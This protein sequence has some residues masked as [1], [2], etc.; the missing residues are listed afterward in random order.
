MITAAMVFGVLGTGTKN[1][2]IFFGI[3]IIAIVIQRVVS[4][5]LTKSF[6]KSSKLL[7]VDE[8]NYHFLR[9]FISA[10]IIIGGV[11]VAIYSIPQLKALSVSLFAGAGILAVIVGFASQQA[12][13]NI[14]SGIFIVIFK[15]FRV[16]D[17][18]TIGNDLRGIVEDINL[19]HTVIR[20]FENK[21]IIVPNS[22][23]SNDKIENASITDEKICRYI[24][25]S[26]SYDSSIDKAM[27]IMEREA[28]K[29][30]LHIDNRDSD[31]KK[32]NDPIVRVRVL[33]LG[34]SSVNLRAW[35][36]A[37]N[38]NNAFIMSCDLNKS[39]KEA[40]D[41]EGIEIPYPYR[42]IVYKKDLPKNKIDLPK[43]NGGLSK[44]NQGLSRN[45][46]YLSKS[47]KK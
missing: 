36:W 18:I 15:P 8:T 20:N 7:K 46:V 40:F 28:L 43:N 37:K 3:V 34:D 13:A 16:G 44:N 27:K 1:T 14:V 31:E 38:S 24:D 10:S 30:P 45:N 4:K 6:K 23:I 35:V 32:N 29:H 21:R 26:I 33:S 41:K 25:F 5:L 47:K 19:R 42:T 12:F 22:M 11:G 17:R 9:H 39:I 2:L